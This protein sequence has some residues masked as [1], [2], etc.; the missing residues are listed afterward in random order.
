MF[1]PIIPFIAP[2]HQTIITP[3]AIG[4]GHTHG[5]DLSPDNGPERGLGAGLH[6]LGLNPASQLQEAEHRC[7]AI[8][9]SLPFT[10]HMPCFDVGLIDSN[11]PFEGRCSLAQLSDSLPNQSK[12]MVYSAAI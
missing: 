9:A 3:P 1:D 8:G 12:V 10:L 7:F 5:S 6:D 2:V 11:P 4:V